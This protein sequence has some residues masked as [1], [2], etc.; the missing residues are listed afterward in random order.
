M[1]LL[2]CRYRKTVST[3][4]SRCCVI[5]NFC[6]IVLMPELSRKQLEDLRA[7]AVRLLDFVE[8]VESVPFDVPA[9]IAALVEQR[10][11][12]RVCLACG[13]KALDDEQ[14]RRGQDSACYATTRSRMRR[15][16]ITE[17]QLVEQGKLTPEKAA[18]GRPAKQDLTSEE[19]RLR[20]AEDLAAYKAKVAARKSKNDGKE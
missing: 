6:Q 11:K 3:T 5:Q 4:A 17:R 9:E 10:V 15:G 14:M 20:V 7:I 2:W 13:Q 12:A 1:L 16:L 18:P 8:S 19:K